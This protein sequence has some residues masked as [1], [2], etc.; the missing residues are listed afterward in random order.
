MNNQQQTSELKPKRARLYIKNNT[1]MEGAGEARTLY[2]H[3]YGDDVNHEDEA[4]NNKVIKPSE[5]CWFDSEGIGNGDNTKKFHIRVYKRN[6]EGADT[7]TLVGEFQKGVYSD[8]FSDGGSAYVDIEKGYID[9]GDKFQ[10][11]WVHNPHGTRLRELIGEI[12]I[13]IWLI[14]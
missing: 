6:S 7:D 1:I 2:I 9:G 13:D 14:D 3:C 8:A 10:L 12:L 11:Y 4:D 5:K